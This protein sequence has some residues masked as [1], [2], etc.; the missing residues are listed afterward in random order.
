MDRFLPNPWRQRAWQEVVAAHGLR[1][2]ETCTSP[3]SRPALWVW[4]GTTWVRF[5][6]TSR[7]STRLVVTVPGP[8]GFAV[9][10]IRRAQAKPADT[11]RIEVGDELFD[12][13]FQAS[14]PLWLIRALFNAEVRSLLLRLNAESR[15]EID[16][17]ELRSEMPETQ[18]TGMLPSFLQ[19]GRLL[20]QPVDI[21]RRLAENAHLDPEPGVRL[22]N[23]RLLALS[24]AR[25]AE[26]A[27][28][29]RIACADES[30][31]VRILAARELGAEGREVLRELAEAPTDDAASA[32]AVSL[33]GRDLPIERTRA[34][35]G[36]ALHNQRVQTARACLE[37]LGGSTAGEDIFRLS[38]VMAHEKSELAAVAATALGSTG[39]P[40]AEELLILALPRAEPADLQVAAANAL[41][42]IGTAVAVLPLKE[43][44]ER[45]ARPTIRKAARRAIAEIQSRL[46]GASPGQLSLAVT[47]AGQLSLAPAEAGQLSLAT[48]P[49]GGLSLSGGE[50]G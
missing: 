46:Q 44:A 1:A 34:I 20:A 19:A 41:A 23:L 25:E 33:L 18:L 6:E 10:R 8:P 21:L 29:L 17:G 13:T 47:E 9:V 30:P 5:E 16:G 42:R 43:L 28:A 35:L 27:E 40:A 12:R 4:A 39:S 3:E 45:T 22:Q 15:L 2:G 48:D 38:E 14:G 31:A 50:D 37:A 32:E 11:S 36:R 26:T 24:H 7:D 49:A